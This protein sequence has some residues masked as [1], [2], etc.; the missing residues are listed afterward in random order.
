MKFVCFLSITL[1]LLLSGGAL[2]SDAE[3]KREA[4]QARLDVACEVA[5]QE[6]LVV[7]RAEKVAICTEQKERSDQASCKRFYSD[8]GAWVGNRP[9]LFYD[10]PACVKAHDYRTSYRSSGI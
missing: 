3:E 1:T 8:Y 5:R 2:A 4:S 7:V 6:K 10:L 9:P